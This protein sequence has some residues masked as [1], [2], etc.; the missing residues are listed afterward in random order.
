VLSTRP[1]DAQGDARRAV[2]QPAAAFALNN[3]GTTQ[4]CP[5]GRR[6]VGWGSE[7]YFSEYDR[8]GKGCVRR[9]VPR[10]N[11]SVPARSCSSGSACRCPTRG[12]H[13]LDE[14]ASRPGM[15]AERRGPSFGVSMRVAGRRRPPRAMTVV[16]EPRQSRAFE[17]ADR[18]A[19][20]LQESI[21]SPALP[22]PTGGGESVLRGAAVRTR[23]R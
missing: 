19:A 3:M 7:P 5:N 17:T 15:R 23:A 9:A 2:R 22:A 20:E 6:F 8:S 18:P 12:R 21:Q 11:L 4:R 13:P 16:G 10:P 14:T 1:A